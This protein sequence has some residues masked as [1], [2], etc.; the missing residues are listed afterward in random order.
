[1]E[2]VLNPDAAKFLEVAE[3]LPIE[4][5]IAIVDRLLESIQ[6]TNSEIDRLWIE[7]V[8]RRVEEVDSGKLKMIPGEEVIREIRERFGR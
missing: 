8:G 3:S 7:E 2:T 6:P 5:R 1:M 4:M